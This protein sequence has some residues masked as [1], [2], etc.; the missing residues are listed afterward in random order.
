MKYSAVRRKRR[1]LLALKQTY[2]R[3]DWKAALNGFTI[4]F[5]DRMPGR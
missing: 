5:K 4:Q 3:Q 1:F 2:G